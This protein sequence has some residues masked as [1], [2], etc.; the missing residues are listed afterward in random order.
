MSFIKCIKKAY[1][2]LCISMLFYLKHDDMIV[3]YKSNKLIQKKIKRKVERILINKMKDKANMY[4]DVIINRCVVIIN[5]W[6][7]K[8]Y[9]K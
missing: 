6:L 9:I 8:Y 2:F 4:T 5:K 7:S 3:Y 1:Y